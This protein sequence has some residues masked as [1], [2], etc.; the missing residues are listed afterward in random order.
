MAAQRLKHQKQVERTAAAQATAAAAAAAAN[1]KG[2]GTQTGNV[3][4]CGSEKHGVLVAEGTKDWRDARYAHP[5][6][7]VRTPAHTKQLWWYVEF[8]HRVT[9]G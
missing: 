2:A 8:E 6:L 5:E 3:M 1:A 4:L 9:Q 7:K